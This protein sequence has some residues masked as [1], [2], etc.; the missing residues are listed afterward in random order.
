[1]TRDASEIGKP[2]FRG[3][4][5]IKKTTDAAVDNEGNYTSFN[6]YNTPELNNIDT[7]VFGESVKDLGKISGMRVK[8]DFKTNSYNIELVNS[9][10]KSK[11]LNNVDPQTYQNIIYDMT[12]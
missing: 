10:N 5:L 1:M 8:Y 11:K 2:E 3:A 9:K 7:S 4:K 12:N 6:I